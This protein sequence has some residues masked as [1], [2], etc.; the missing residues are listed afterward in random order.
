MNFAYMHQLISVNSSRF[1]RAVCW[2]FAHDAAYGLSTLNDAHASRFDC[3]L[4]F[5]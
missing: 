4:K 5:A 2:R 3:I 1:I